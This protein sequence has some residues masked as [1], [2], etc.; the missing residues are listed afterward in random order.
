MGSCKDMTY[1]LD[2]IRILFSPS[3][4]CAIQAAY[5]DIL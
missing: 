2:Y 4:A 1:D 5:F 3:L